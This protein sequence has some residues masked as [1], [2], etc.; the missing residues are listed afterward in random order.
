MQP[1]NPRTLL[2]RVLS[3]ILAFPF[4]GTAFSQAP[5][6]LPSNPSF[7]LNQSVQTLEW[8]KK[9][10]ETV[11]R[12]DLVPDTCYR[13]EV[14]GYRS[15]CHTE[16]DRQCHTEL[17][18]Q[19]GFRHYPV[20]NNVPR[21]VC[22]PRQV[23]QRGMF[24]ESL[25]LATTGGLQVPA[26]SG[27][28]GHPPRP[29]GPRPLP[30]GAGNGGGYPHP[31]VCHT[32]T[33]C[34]TVYD[35]VCHHEQ[36]YECWNNPQTYCRDIPRQA[37]TQVP[38]IVQVPYACTKPVQVAIGQNLKLQTNVRLTAI[39]DNFS[40][41]G[42]LSDTLT[43]RL[44]GNEI[45]LSGSSD[46][47]LYQ[48]ANQSFT[49][50]RISENARILN[51][52]LHL[53]VLPLERL[54]AFSSIEIRNGRIFEDRI[55]FDLSKAPEIPFR[56]HLKL[57]RHRALAHE[58]EIVDADFD[59]T[60]LG[61]QGMTQVLPLRTFGAGP[62]KEKRHKARL[63]LTLDGDFL[64]QG[65]VNPSVLTGIRNLPVEGSFEASL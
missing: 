60:R 1:K 41:V 18:Q 14:Q 56:G 20:C 54:N 37:C 27:G 25:A 28:P 16:Y 38:N 2:I 30:G 59:S 5:A 57:T 51:V 29:G 9:D 45:R 58:L 3:L 26:P 53:R 65:A 17:N 8:E 33:Q 21:T 12:T 24:L 10:Y 39:F 22:S 52:E 35:R 63:R 64:R 36:R 34:T 6:N 42:P 47:V 31:P 40:E 55:E 44:E 48:V 13:S 4:P 49:E 23:C 62:L 46:R 32:Q 19:C 61:G 7:T 11:Y 15:E 43:A 50:Q